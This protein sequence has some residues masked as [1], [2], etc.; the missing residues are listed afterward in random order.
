MALA[1]RRQDARGRGLKLPDL[2]STVEWG[3]VSSC[4][5][6]CRSISFGTLFE[7]LDLPCNARRQVK[8]PTGF[9][10]LGYMGS[11]CVD[12]IIFSTDSKARGSSAYPRSLPHPPM[13][14][15]VMTPLEL[16]D[17]C[18]AYVMELWHKGKH[19]VGIREVADITALPLTG[20]VWAH[21]SH[22]GSCLFC[23][24]SLLLDK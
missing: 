18:V 1:A 4:H 10:P 24:S 19:L 17:A 15:E 11:V 8:R 12:P 9:A 3:N 2:D 23:K 6:P 13:S 20:R 14:C 5:Y 16:R 7:L 21:S 22:Y